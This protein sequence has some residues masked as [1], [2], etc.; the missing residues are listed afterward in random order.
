MGGCER[1]VGILWMQKMVA[2][3]TKEAL[4]NEVEMI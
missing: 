2:A 3:S 1:L 4:L